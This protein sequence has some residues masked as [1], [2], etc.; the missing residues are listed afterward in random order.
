MNIHLSNF[1]TALDYLKK[2]LAI[3]QE[4][5]DKAGLC[6]TLFNMGHI[7]MQNNE[8]QKAMQA[9]LEVYGIAKKIQLA[10]G[11]QALEKLANELGLPGG[12]LNGWETLA[13][14]LDEP[15]PPDQPYWVY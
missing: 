9:W 8:R 1:E 15:G 14:K 7:Y 11:L 2:S 12:G 4:I 3:Q 6:A 10:Q 5:G 13:G